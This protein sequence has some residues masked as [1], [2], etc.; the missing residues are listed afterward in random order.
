MLEHIKHLQ[1]ELVGHAA[2]F[3]FGSK[4]K[5]LPVIWLRFWQSLQKIIPEE[6]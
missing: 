2:E 3:K 6:I 5:P 4:F 1:L